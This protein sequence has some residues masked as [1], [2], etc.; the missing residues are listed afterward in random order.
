M[1]VVDAMTPLGEIGDPVLALFG[2][3]ATG[4]SAV[5]VA[6]VTTLGVKLKK[7]NSTVGEVRDQVSNDHDTNLRDDLDLMRDE[8]REL[9]S[10]L[11]SFISRFDAH[12]SSVTADI[13]GLRKDIGRADERD[14]EDERELRKLRDKMD[15]VE[16]RIAALEPTQPGPGQVL[17]APSTGYRPMQPS[18]EA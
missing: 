13:R 2:T 8:S 6:V 9:A 12:A 3:I 10:T 7:T 16:D 18:Q 17:A 15:N 5:L 1:N 4:I 11:K 14:I